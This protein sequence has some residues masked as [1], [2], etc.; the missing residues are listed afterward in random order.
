L[1]ENRSVPT[2]D[3]APVSAEEAEALFADLARSRALVIA[4]SG[5][6]DSTALLVL[7]ARWHAA[8]KQGPHLLAVTVDHGL[9]PES[10]RE[11]RA[12]KRLAGRLGVRHRVLRWSGEKPATG[13]QEAARAARYQLLSA[14]ARSAGARHIL[15][16]HTLDD[17]AETVLI[18]MARG[19]GLTGLCAM[20]RE[21]A[22]G[23]LSLLR[24]LLDLPKARLIATLDAVGL[25]FADDPSNRNPRFTRARMRRLM[26][27]LAEEGLDAARLALLARRLRRVEATL[28]L[29]VT[30]A[31]QALCG[32]A[33]QN[34]APVVIEAE[35]F[36]G[37]PDE[38][39]LRLLGRAVAWTGD[40]GPVELGKLEALFEALR[41]V[42]R[43]SNPARLRR[44]LAG[45]LVT[46]AGGRLAIERAPPRSFKSAGRSPTLTK[47]GHGRRGKAKRR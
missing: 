21:T 25:S 47:R 12:V 27:A 29:A 9:R 35:K 23:E 38:I 32:D 22:L 15:T 17:Q 45:A 11:A 20:S 26:P 14:A 44:T 4:V 36:G 40:E 31:V 37:L 2:A 8:L 39:A 16:G 3:A 6:P 34:D 1:N 28:E 7:A 18:R 19:S 5:G 41:Q 42:Q 10:A 43:Q 30:A 13:L 33:W 24:P 46:L